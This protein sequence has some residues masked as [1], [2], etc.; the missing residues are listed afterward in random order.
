MVF[1]LDYAS[2]GGVSPLIERH[3][4]WT[5]FNFSNDDLGHGSIFIRINV[6]DELILLNQSSFLFSSLQTIAVGTLLDMMPLE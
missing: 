2:G 1:G 3:V 5:D 4:D 6:L